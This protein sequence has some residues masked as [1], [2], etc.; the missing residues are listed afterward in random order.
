MSSAPPG[1]V[2]FDCDGVLVD[3][4]P[5]A[6]RVLGRMLAEQGWALDEAQL[7]E[8]FLGRTMAHCLALVAERL[9]RPLPAGFRAE[10]DRR[11][12][13]ALAAELVPV[14]GVE[15]VLDGLATPSC[16]ASNGGPDKLRFSLAQVGL[17]PRFEG[18]VFSAAEVACGKPAPD[19]FLH[20][21]RCMGVAPAACVVVEDSPAGVLA[22]LAAGMTVLGFAAR[23]PPARLHEA[24]AHQVFSAMSRFPHLAGMQMRAW[25]GRAGSP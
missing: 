15:Q 1:L 7:D 21:A 14:P 2:I 6:N 13:D 22:G 10:H 4:E 23:T 3:S 9:G 11:L 25:A 5:I 12:F 8:L 24:G 16:V 19:L 17:L 18:R 20:A